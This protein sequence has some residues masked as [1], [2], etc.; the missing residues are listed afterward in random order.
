[1]RHTDRYV[2]YFTGWSALYK[3]IEYRNNRLV[4]FNREAFLAEILGP[5]KALEQLGGY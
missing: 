3:L 5:Q 2:I 1:M 4:A